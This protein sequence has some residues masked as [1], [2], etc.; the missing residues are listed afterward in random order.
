[1]QRYTFVLRVVYVLYRSSRKAL[2][3]VV[4]KIQHYTTQGFSEEHTA[5][6]VVA[7]I[8]GRTPVSHAESANPILILP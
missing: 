6:I 2:Q 8:S 7:V 4:V 3:G 1:M 5:A